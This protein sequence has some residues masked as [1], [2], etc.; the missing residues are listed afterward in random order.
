MGMGDRGRTSIAAFAAPHSEVASCDILI[1][2]ANVVTMD[3]ERSVHACGAV[4]VR[5]CEIVAV[6][7]AD[8]VG[9]DCSATRVVDAGGA[10]VHPGLV[11]PHCHV[12]VHTSRGGIP[13][14]PPDPHATSARAGFGAF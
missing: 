11:E 14:Y 9:A 1:T 8:E 6:G 7:P 10:L 13:D 12:T 5:G 4:A 2:N 3:D